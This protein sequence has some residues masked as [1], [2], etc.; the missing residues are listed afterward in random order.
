MTTAN[1]RAVTS[2]QTKPHADLLKRFTK[3]QQTAY[4]KP[5]QAHNRQAFQDALA[6]WQQQGQPPI[7]LDS[8]CGV[9]NS[10]V[11]LA[12]ANPQGLVIGVDKSAVRLNKAVGQYNELANLYFVRA[13]LVDFWRLA[14]QAGWR[15]TAHYLLYP[16]P[17]PKPKHLARRWPGHPVFSTL[18][19]LGGWLEVR[20]NWLIYLEEVSVVVANYLRQDQPVPVELLP[21]TDLAQ[22]LTPFEKKYMASQ[23][24]LYYCR[25]NL[26]SC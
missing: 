1:S 16:N 7:I 20:S 24:Q 25:V 19:A 21:S 12:Q 17:Y 6:Y 8:G 10:S 2:Q 3:H 26:V 13:D 15:L 11:K 14:R 22:C 5:I 18:L 9:G 4:L 23:Q